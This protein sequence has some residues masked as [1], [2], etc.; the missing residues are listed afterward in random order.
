MFLFKLFIKSWLY[1]SI[2]YAYKDAPTIDGAIELENKYVRARFF[3]IST[4]Y[5]EPAIKPPEA[6]P[7]A[8]P[9]VELTKSIFPYNP[10]ISGVPLPV[11]PI[12]PAAWH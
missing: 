6:P 1:E 5:L 7:I 4:V 8:F 3:N 2:L 10:K 11:L 12:N 9:K